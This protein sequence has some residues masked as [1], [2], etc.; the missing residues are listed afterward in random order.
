MPGA[1]CVQELGLAPWSLL[2]VLSAEALCS[3]PPAFWES[4]KGGLHA[5][6]PSLLSRQ[7]AAH[8]RCPSCVAD[9]SFLPVLV[10]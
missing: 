10:L 8:S 7:G 4:S 5:P 6:S 1:I 2:A 3:Q 9:G